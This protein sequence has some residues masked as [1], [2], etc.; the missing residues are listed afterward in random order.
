[1]HTGERPYKC[2]FCDYNCRDA[3]GLKIHLRKHTGEKPYKCEFCDYATTS[4]SGL[5]AH[6]NRKHSKNA[7]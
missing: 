1:M 5:K 4:S 6:T 7:I 3:S 2:S